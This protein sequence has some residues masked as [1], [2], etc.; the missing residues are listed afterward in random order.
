MSDLV[1]LVW[2]L[3][4][5]V[6]L[7]LVRPFVKSIRDIT[8]I[9][10]FP[11]LA[12]VLLLLVL[13]IYGFRPELVPLGVFIFI[14]VLFRIP[15]LISLLQRLREDE[16]RTPSLVLFFIGFLFLSVTGAVAIV[17]S[18]SKEFLSGKDTA[19]LAA[20]KD[21]YE[22]FV[23][24][25]SSVGTEYFIRSYKVSAEKTRGTIL[26]IPPVSGSV[27]VV[28]SICTPLFAKGLSI[29]TLSQNGLDL[30]AY[31]VLHKPVAPSIKRTAEYL[32]SFIAGLRYKTPNEYGRSIEDERLRAIERVISQ[33]EYELPLYIIGYG[34]GG[35]AALR[36]LAQHKD[37]PVSALINIE[38]PLFYSLEFNERDREASGVKG[39]F[40]TLLPRSFSHIGTVPLI[41]KPLMVLVS[42]RIKK[43][44]ER[45]YRYATL[46]RVVHQAEAPAVLVALTG[47]GPFDYSD[48]TVQ[49][50]IYSALMSGIGN[51]VRSSDY[52]VES[53]AALINNFI[54]SIEKMQT[55]ASDTAR[56]VPYPVSGDVYM[57]YNGYSNS[58]NP[59]EVLG[60]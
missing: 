5:L 17:F 24:K 7:E 47:A 33:G 3:I 11:I 14:I 46:V 19:P 29:V 28:D 56:G 22:T 44:E 39:F 31:D 10:L 53:T 26:V 45:D 23:L 35:A 18:P 12:L 42:D 13:Y 15:K 36:Y 52:Y 37:N 1:L 9:I 58:Y 34:A 43:T 57:E 51:R 21:N 49:Y 8:G 55:E 48:V 27:E 2:L 30:P 41:E 20:A 6:G 59:R 38:G 60:K 54:C 16:D 40:A 32:L 50:P 4:V 25:D